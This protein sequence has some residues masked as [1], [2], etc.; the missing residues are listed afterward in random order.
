MI[1]K[2]NSK[3]ERDSARGRG[4]GRGRGGRDGHHF[5]SDKH[6][7][8]NGS[9]HGVDSSNF[10]RRFSGE[11]VN[12]DGSNGRMY[13]FNKRKSDKDTRHIQKVQHGGTDDGKELDLKPYF[14]EANGNINLG[15]NENPNESKE[16]RSAQ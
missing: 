10:G 3:R 13:D 12:K 11:N 5:G 1:S 16:Q 2:F 4:H 7:S 6:D 14:G 8:A 9:F 15:G